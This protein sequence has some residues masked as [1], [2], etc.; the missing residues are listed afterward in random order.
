MNGKGK[1][2]YRIEYEID[3]VTKEGWVRFSGITGP[4]LRM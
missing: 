2:A 3:E 1:T 4:D